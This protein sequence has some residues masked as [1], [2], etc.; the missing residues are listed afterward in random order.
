[1]SSP[2]V[3]YANKVTDEIKY[4][5]ILKQHTVIHLKQPELLLVKDGGH[6]FDLLIIL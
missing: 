5:F 4:A 2:N 6:K 3:Y 1:M